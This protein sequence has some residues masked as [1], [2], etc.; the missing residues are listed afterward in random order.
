MPKLIKVLRVERLGRSFKLEIDGE[1][2]PYA[3]SADEPIETHM[4]A[5]GVPSL[6]FTLFAERL[7]LVDEPSPSKA[8]TNV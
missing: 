6:R 7:E 8:T 4:D 1:D 2:F 5:D 3:V